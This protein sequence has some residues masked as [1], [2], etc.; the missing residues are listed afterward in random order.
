M[1]VARVA[2]FVGLALLAGCA[3]E[4]PLRTVPSLDLARY[5]GDWYVIAHLPAKN[6]R[7]A[8]DAIEHYDVEGERIRIRYTFREGSHEGE[9]QELHMR[10]W[11]HD[12]RTRAEWRVRPF[13]P[14]ALA[15]VVVA[16]DPDYQTTV[17]AH[18]SRKYAWIMARTPTLAPDALEPLVE[19]LREQ[20]FDTTRLRYVPQRSPAVPD[21]QSTAYAE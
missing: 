11:V 14:L 13:W 6:E 8:Y 12:E 2:L 10:G 21:P 17:V 7:N 3:R 15:Y 20:G 19:T 1:S 18:P 4:A 5:A 16:L 9:R